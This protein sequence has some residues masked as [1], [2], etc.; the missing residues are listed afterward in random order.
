MY[1]TSLKVLSHHPDC[2]MAWIISHYFTKF[3]LKETKL[4]IS[5]AISW[6][7]ILACGREGRQQGVLVSLWALFSLNLELMESQLKALESTN[8][9]MVDVTHQVYQELRW[10]SIHTHKN[11]MLKWR[12]GLL[13]FTLSYSRSNIGWIFLC[14][15]CPH[16][17]GFWAPNKI[18]F[19]HTHPPAI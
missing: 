5:M 15:Y 9:G 11:C 3:V 1:K 2:Q 8:L 16:H 10:S 12:T 6:Y 18:W 19:Y 14:L 17:D 7:L 13:S 4:V